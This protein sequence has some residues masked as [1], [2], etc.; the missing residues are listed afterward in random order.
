MSP[1]ALPKATETDT[2]AVTVEPHPA[3]DECWQCV[4]H[5]NGSR[6]FQGGT[7]RTQKSARKATR[8]MLRLRIQIHYGQ[9]SK[10]QQA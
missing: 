7:F 8:A 4:I 9:A 5:L 2:W 10:P 1:Y 6:L 3:E